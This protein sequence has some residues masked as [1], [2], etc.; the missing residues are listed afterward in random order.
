[1]SVNKQIK[2][3]RIS[4]T[5]EPVVGQAERGNKSFQGSSEALERGEEG[6]V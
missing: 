1:M 6:H 3:D 2:G 5:E 4:N